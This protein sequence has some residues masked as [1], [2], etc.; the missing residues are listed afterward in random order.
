MSIVIGIDFFRWRRALWRRKIS[1]R[2]VWLA[3][4]QSSGTVPRLIH[5]MPAQSLEGN[6]PPFDRLVQ[7]LAAGDFD[8]A[9]ID[10]PF[11]LPLAH[12]PRGGH[13]EL[14]RGAR[15]LSNA[16]DRPFPLGAR[17]VELGESVAPKLQA[18]P[19][20]QTEAFWALE[21]REYPLH[22]VGRTTGW[23]SIRSSMPS[24]TG[25]GTTAMPAVGN[26]SIRNPSGS[27]SGCSAAPLGATSSRVFTSRRS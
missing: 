3:T 20:R 26:V 4:V 11:S 9:A 7:L 22:Y 14:L 5:L 15:A 17:I 25:T 13:V 6:G 12:M 27:I 21:R 18:K 19:L 2:T 16:D 24:A 10:A 1:R 23:C 8:A